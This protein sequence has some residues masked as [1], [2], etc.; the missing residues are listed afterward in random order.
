MT[1]KSRSR[2]FGENIL[3]GPCIFR[4]N[5]FAYST[6]P[7]SPI[8]IKAESVRPAYA[9]QTGGLDVKGGVP[10]TSA[11]TALRRFEL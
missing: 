11:R 6:G 2:K 1:A 10:E 3:L 7:E 5:N 4:P 8:L 9:P